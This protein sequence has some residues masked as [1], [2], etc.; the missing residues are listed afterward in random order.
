MYVDGYDINDIN[1][2]WRNESLAVLISEEA[3]HFST[4]NLE[5][6]EATNCS[7][8]SGKI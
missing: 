2:E 5:S 1:F 4:F 8:E 7:S 3:S 6:Y